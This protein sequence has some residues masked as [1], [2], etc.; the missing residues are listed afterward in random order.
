MSMSVYMYMCRWYVCGSWLHYN[1]YIG[2]YERVAEVCTGGG[3]EG[4]GAG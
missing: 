1:V 4:E 3:V 2:V